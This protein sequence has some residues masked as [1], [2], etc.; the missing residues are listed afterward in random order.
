MSL[1]IPAVTLGSGFET[2]RNHSLEELIIID[3]DKDVASMAVGLAAVLML[4]DAK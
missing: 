1:G 2:Q 4:A 3:K